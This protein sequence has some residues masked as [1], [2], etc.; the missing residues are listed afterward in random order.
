MAEDILTKV[1][2]KTPKGFTRNALAYGAL[3]S[4]SRELA[5]D[6]WVTVEGKILPCMSF[7]VKENGNLLLEVC[8]PFFELTDT[9][10]TS[11]RSEST[12]L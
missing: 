12:G 7:R 10:T 6:T 8:Q 2:I 5:K 4:H 9:D 1:I 3:D 11:A